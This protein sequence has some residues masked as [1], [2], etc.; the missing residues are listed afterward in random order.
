MNRRYTA[1][2]EIEVPNG[3]A[4]DWP[5]IEGNIL[6]A[7]MAYDGRGRLFNGHHSPDHTSCLLGLSIGLEK[8]E[9]VRDHWA[10]LKERIPAA[11]PP[12]F[13]QAAPYLER[14][15]SATVAI[16]R[17]IEELQETRSAIMTAWHDMAKAEHGRA[18]A[19]ARRRLRKLLD[20]HPGPPETPS[21]RGI[22]DQSAP[23]SRK[24]GRLKKP[25]KTR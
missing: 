13:D 16:G 18:F 24:H 15:V 22:T 11:Q 14:S 8:T 7:I 23:A 5:G 25:Q 17:Q 20:Q 9:V 2:L 1:E 19:G 12:F 10:Q 3:L 6:D 4:L 21:E